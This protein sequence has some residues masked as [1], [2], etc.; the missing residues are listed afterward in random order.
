MDFKFSEPPNIVD[1]ERY[2]KKDLQRFFHLY[3]FC[4]PTRN[5]NTRVDQSPYRKAKRLSHQALL[6]FQNKQHILIAV[7]R[8]KVAFEIL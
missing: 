5:S 8:V 1:N 2:I 6:Q 4:L 3:Q 7:M